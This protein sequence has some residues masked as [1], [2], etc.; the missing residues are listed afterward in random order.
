MPNAQPIVSIYRDYNPLNG[1][2]MVLYSVYG[3]A[4]CLDYG[5][6]F[7]IIYIEFYISHY[8]QRTRY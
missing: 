5:N 6:I 7:V 1:W 4:Y 2:Y 3:L 8:I